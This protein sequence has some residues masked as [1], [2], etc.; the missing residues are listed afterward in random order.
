MKSQTLPIVLLGAAAIVLALGFLLIERPSQAQA[1][2][3]N[4]NQ[5]GV[6]TTS[7]LFSVTTSTRIL[8]TTT[9]PTDPTNSYIRTYA[10]ICTNGSN[11]IAINIDGDKAANLPTGKL[12]TFIAAAAGYNAC[13]E[14]TDRNLYQGSVTASSTNQTASNVFVK[15]YVQ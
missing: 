8:A 2:N 15:D 9:N 13:F 10:S 11:P 6:A 4:S 12:T 3:A 5:I 1:A 14:I 7:A